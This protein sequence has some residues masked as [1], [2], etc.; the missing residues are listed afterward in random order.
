MDSFR[1]KAF[2]EEESIGNYKKIK[3]HFCFKCNG[4]WKIFEE[5]DTHHGYFRHAIRVGEKLNIWNKEY[6]FNAKEIDEIDSSEYEKLTDQQNVSKDSEKSKIDY[7]GKLKLAL[8]F[9]L[10]SF[11]IIY[12]TYKIIISYKIKKSGIET[13]SFLEEKKRIRGGKLLRYSYYFKLKYKLKNGKIESTQ[14]N[15]SKQE[16]NLYIEGDSIAVLYNKSIPK[17]V[18]IKEK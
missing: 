10:L 2:T 4:Y 15:V 6:S 17:E 5:Y 12:P 11:V 8:L 3:I 18:E 1:K 14:K 7:L 16:Y 9:A 13:K